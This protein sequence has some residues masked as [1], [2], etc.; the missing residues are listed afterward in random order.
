MARAPKPTP[1]QWETRTVLALPRRA[2]LHP[3]DE[4][5]VRVCGFRLRRVRFLTWTRNHDTGREWINVFDGKAIRSF[6]LSAVHTVHR[7]RK[8]PQRGAP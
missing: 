3:D 6:D 1:A 2:V 4:L 5:T 7:D 8:M